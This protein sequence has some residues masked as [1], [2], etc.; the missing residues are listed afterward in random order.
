M[1]PMIKK[2]VGHIVPATG[3]VGVT[4]GVGVGEAA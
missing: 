4:L 3:T 1:P 2:A